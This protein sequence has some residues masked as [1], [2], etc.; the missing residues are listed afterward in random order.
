MRYERAGLAAKIFLAL[1]HQTLAMGIPSRADIAAYLHR[2]DNSLPSNIVDIFQGPPPTCSLHIKESVECDTK[3]FSTS[4]I[5]KDAHGETVA[6][7]GKPE[8]EYGENFE[9]ADVQYGDY[10]RTFDLQN[11]LYIRIMT[12]LTEG[13]KIVPNSAQD[14]IDFTYGPTTWTTKD[15]EKPPREPR[16][17][18]VAS[19]TDSWTWP[20]PTDCSNVP[21]SKEKFWETEFL[22][23]LTV[24]GSVGVE[25]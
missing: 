16:C 12:G 4:V 6:R 9:H 22:L 19:T 5:V 7:R 17:S 1:G 21:P 20:T 13:L 2:R 24:R 10:G 11:P 18:L 8:D 3:I 25:S 14:S 15:L 23:M